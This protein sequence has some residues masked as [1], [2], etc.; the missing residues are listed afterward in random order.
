MNFKKA[1]KNSTKFGL[2]SVISTAVLSL[3]DIKRLQVSERDVEI[4]GAKPLKI[5]HIS[6]LHEFSYGEKNSRLVKEIVKRKPDVIC[7]TGDMV[8]GT[9]PTVYNSLYFL[10]ALSELGIPVLYSIGNHELKLSEYLPEFYEDYMTKVKSYGI[11]VLDDACIS[12]DGYDFYGYTNKMTQYPRFKGLYSLKAKEITSSIGKPQN[13]RTTVLLAHNPL[14]FSAYARWGA[15]LTLSG[16][17]HGGIVRLPFIGGLLC[18]QT[19]IS[20][21]YTGG[22]YKKGTRQMFVSRGLGV[23][24]IHIRVFNRPELAFLNINGRGNQ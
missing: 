12:F 19:F 23:H 13:E 10:Q 4:P 11:H 15:D 3:F 14:Y 1:V 7:I 18:P 5:A 9:Q 20:V 22:L 16:H 24:S 17:L 6:D 8:L 2:F 21:G